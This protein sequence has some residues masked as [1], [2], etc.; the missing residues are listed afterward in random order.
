MTIP[1]I[2]LFVLNALVVVVLAFIIIRVRQ[3]GESL[4]PLGASYNGPPLGSELDLEALGV[5]HQSRETVGTVVAFVA[6]DCGVCDKTLR[7][8]ESGTAASDAFGGVKVFLGEPSDSAAQKS[9]L[10]P[11][12]EQE[13]FCDPQRIDELGI[14]GFPTVLV[15]DRAGIIV[16]AGNTYSDV[17]PSLVALSSQ[18]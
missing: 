11:S 8:L 3:I 6:S 9:A 4:G 10:W 15:V 7:Q 12:A 2:V 5:S 13:L 16:S 1:V 14:Q 17:E 18:T